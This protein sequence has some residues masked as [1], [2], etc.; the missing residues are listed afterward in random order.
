MPD[1]R[2]GGNLMFQL[3]RLCIG[4]AQKLVKGACLD[5]PRG[6]RPYPGRAVYLCLTDTASFEAARSWPCILGGHAQ[7]SR[8]LNLYCDSILV[9]SMSSSPKGFQSHTGCVYRSRSIGIL[10]PA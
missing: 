9:V 3:S 10:V 8:R 6:L 7:E 5:M 2:G 1:W 4:K